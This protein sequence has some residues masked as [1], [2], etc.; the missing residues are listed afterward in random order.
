VG[1]PAAT[2][3]AVPDPAAVPADPQAPLLN[4]ANAIT[5][6]RLLL[7]PVFAAFTVASDLTEPGLRIAAALSFGVA[8]MTDYVDGWVA[9]KHN[10]VTSFGK[11]ADPIAD[12]AL[13]GTALVLLSGYGLVPWWITVLIVVREVGVT[14]LRFMVLRHGVIPASRGGKLKT[15]VQALAIGWLLWPLPSG[16]AVVG[17]LLIY[18]ATA[19]TVG[20][21]L[22][23]VVRAVRLR[24]AAPARRSVL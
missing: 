8:S 21:G 22:D 10:L 14:A 7:V 23:Y 19:I 12:K 13:T 5:A 17:L 2:V 16:A 15:L 20:T 6:V 18:A 4:L 1:E 11:V 3:P 9:R 24:R